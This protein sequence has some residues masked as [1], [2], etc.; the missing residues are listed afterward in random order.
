MFARTKTHHSQNMKNLAFHM[1]QSFKI[2]EVTPEQA[3]D[4]GA[5]TMRRFLGN[6]Y[7]FI[8]ATHSNTNHVHNHII[9]NSVNMINGKSFSREHDRKADPAWLSL[10][11]ISDEILVEN[12]LSVITQPEK[13]GKS[14]YEWSM[15][16]SGKSWKSKL[17]LII[18]ET[19]R[20]ADDFD[21]FLEQMRSQN[22]TVKYEPYK[23]KEGMILAFKMDGQ[24]NFIYSQKL[25]K[26]YHEDSIRSRIE[27]SVRSRNMTPTE[28]RQE[29]ILSDDGK[30][31]RLID[32]S[33]MD[34]IAFQTWAKNENRKI[35][36]QTLT[37]LHGR[38]F[39]CFHEL[40]LYCKELSDM[41]ENN[42]EVYTEMKRQLVNVKTL[43]RYAEIYHDYKEI[44]DDYKNMTLF[45][46]R[47]FRRHETEIL[48]FEQAKEEL[49][50]YG[51]NI[52]N[53]AQLKNKISEMENYLTDLRN[54]NR[55]L[56][57]KLHSFDTLMYNLGVIY[58]DLPVTQTDRQPER[59]FLDV[60]NDEHEDEPEPEPEQHETEI[61]P[62]KRCRSDDFDIEL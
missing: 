12:G 10:R 23:T 34:D 47:F 61:A 35:K 3:H 15:D 45:D 32:V 36:M 37:E 17:K 20:S 11:K 21:G 6:Q 33:R 1:I 48:L 55:E 50:K 26:Y 51:D 59:S 60:Y 2:G 27:R 8:V 16:K 49:E 25:G 9:I 54:T 30:L 39:S 44:Y 53:G 40:K 22:I 19:I 14:H 18:D 28:R 13:T 41:I 46:D 29:R 4:I 62:P 43:K 7:E 31:K 5:E 56:R 38:G 57:K 52:P 42:S 58:E 24:K